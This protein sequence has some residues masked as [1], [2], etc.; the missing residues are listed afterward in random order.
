M[1]TD[2]KVRVKK[3][4]VSPSGVLNQEEIEI[5]TDVLFKTERA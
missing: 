4:T 2:R 1:T 5:C 3:C